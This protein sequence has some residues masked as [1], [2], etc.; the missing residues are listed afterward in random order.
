M[1]NKKN[2]FTLIELLVVI[3]IIAILMAI[4]LPALNSV[5]EQARSTVCRTRLR[6]MGMTMGVYAADYDNK[7]PDSQ[8]YYCR[9]MHKLAPYYD[10]ATQGDDA[11]QIWGVYS[12]SV[13][14][15][16]TQEKY[17]PAATGLGDGYGAAGIYGYNRFFTA[18]ANRAY[19]M[20]RKFTDIRNPSN[21]PLFGDMD[22]KPNANGEFTGGMHYG[23]H[24]EVFPHFTALDYGWKHKNYVAQAGGPAPVHA[25]KI[26]H[27]MADS[28]VITVNLDDWEFDSSLSAGGI[29]GWTKIFHPRNA[30]NPLMYPPTR[31]ND[32][33]E[34]RGN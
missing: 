23:G 33:P 14:R 9:W 21:L 12:W 2:A 15:C 16:P 20:W 31:D 4:M 34:N 27:L 3:S 17:A 11:K 29:L 26:N 32:V 13:Y 7:L 19:Y 24:R 8:W 5:R 6:D 1:S 10:L 22:A 18:E 30:V 28:R 25:G